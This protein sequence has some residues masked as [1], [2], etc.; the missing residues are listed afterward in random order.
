MDYYNKNIE[1]LEIYKK[2]SNSFSISLKVSKFYKLKKIVI[3]KTEQRI[4][5]IEVKDCPLLEEIRFIGSL[6]Y[7]KDI[8]FKLNGNTK[9]HFPS[10]FNSL[11]KL[12]ISGYNFETLSL[13]IKA[14]NLEILSLVNFPNLKKLHIPQL[15]SLRKIHLENISDCLD[16]FLHIKLPYSINSLQSLTIDNVK[17]SNYVLDVS[18]NSLRKLKY[19]NNSHLNS[20]T[21]S[22]D[23][24]KIEKLYIKNNNIKSLVLNSNLENLKHLKIKDSS[25][26]EVNFFS[27]FL[28]LKSISYYNTHIRNLSSYSNQFKSLKEIK[29]ISASFEELNIK[30]K[31]EH[32]KKLVISKLVDPWINNPDY[33][34]YVFINIKG[35]KSNLKHVDI[36]NGFIFSE[37]T[38]KY[39]SKVIEDDYIPHLGN[40]IMNTSLLYN[41]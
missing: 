27:E 29:I 11:R 21:F 1:V 7:L 15:Q 35:D 18:T 28:K 3:Y 23:L 6:T 26:E 34:K 9:I 16:D 13:N 40:Y 32:L 10:C 25:I 37:T 31:L 39:L 4:I 2:L 33:Y 8:D 14:S 5:S 38:L 41:K 19:F 22:E 24:P 12:N 20:L 17:L 36:N 30:I